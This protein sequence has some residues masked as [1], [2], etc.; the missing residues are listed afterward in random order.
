MQI[1]NM[2]KIMSKCLNYLIRNKIIIR[3]IIRI[4]KKEIVVKI[5]VKEKN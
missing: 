3:N 1:I 4:E 5:A 2:F